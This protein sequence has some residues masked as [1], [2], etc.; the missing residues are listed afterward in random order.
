MSIHWPRARS[1]DADSQL[2]VYSVMSSCRV[3]RRRFEGKTIVEVRAEFSRS[4]DPALVLLNENVWEECGQIYASWD[5]FDGWQEMLDAAA[6]NGQ[7]LAMIRK[8]EALISDADTFDEG[9]SLLNSAIQ[10]EELLA[11]AFMTDVYIGAGIDKN[12]AYGW[13]LAA[14]ELGLDCSPDGIF[15]SSMCNPFS[16]A[17]SP[18]ESVTG[19]SLR[20]L[21]DGGLYV[22]NQE[23]ER[24][25]RA[26]ASGRLEDLDL[27]AE[28]KNKGTIGE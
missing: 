13:L 12:V 9:V 28:L 21:G 16:E 4:R 19:M 11:L 20:E 8:G 15:M 25:Y 26:I 14:C 24:I 10:D 5:R 18:H 7:P 22:A 6:D 27:A 2:I 1:G 3:Y 17:C 23:A